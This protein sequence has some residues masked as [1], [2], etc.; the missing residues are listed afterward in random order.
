M[1]MKYLD[2][3]NLEFNFGMDLVFENSNIKHGIKRVTPIII[4]NNDIGVPVIKLCFMNI[5]LNE[6]AIVKTRNGII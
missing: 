1:L 3:L 6:R 5:S 4:N 2:K